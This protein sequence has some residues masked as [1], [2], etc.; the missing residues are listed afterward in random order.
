MLIGTVRRYSWTMSNLTPEKRLDKTGKL[1]TRH[2][3]ASIGESS[4]PQMPAPNL[5]TVEDVQVL[6]VSDLEIANAI[7]RGRERFGEYGTRASSSLRALAEYDPE[8]FREVND[9]IASCSDYRAMLWGLILEANFG[10]PSPAYPKAV[11]MHASVMDVIAEMNPDVRINAANGNNGTFRAHEIWTKSQHMIKGHGATLKTFK[12]AAFAIWATRYRKGLSLDTEG[13]DIKFIAENFKAVMQHRDVIW[14]RKS[15]DR[16]FIESVISTAA[17]AI[18][19]G[20][21]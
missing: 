21:L 2:V 15:I 4:V 12:A 8:V 17:P 9:S 1:V 6:P 14:E 13:H 20:V 3:R 10:K 11:M 18:S 16:E 19:K 7:R 5:S